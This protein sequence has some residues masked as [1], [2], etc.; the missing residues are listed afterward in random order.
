[1]SLIFKPFQI[2]QLRIK[3]RFIRSATVDN[4]GKDMM[5]SQSQLDLYHELTLGEMG[6]IISSGLFPSLDGWAAPGQLGIH[7]D[8]MIPSLAKLVDIVHRNDGKLAAQIMHA[9]WFGNPELCGY[10]AIGP[11]AMTNPANNLQVR[12]LSSEEVYECVEIFIQAAR[13][14]IEAGFDAVQ[15]HCAHSWLVSAFLSP[16]T[17]LREDE[18]GGSIEKRARFLVNIIQGVRRLA[19]PDFPILIKLGLKDYHPLGKSLNEGINSAQMFINAGVDAIE[20]SEGIE[21]QPF[22][23]I[24]PD[25]VKP[26]YTEECRQARPILDVPV[27][28]VGGMRS[29]SEINQ[30]VDNGIADAVSMCRPF[31]MDQ[32]IVKKFRLKQTKGSECISCNKCIEEMHKQNIH[33]IFNERLIQNPR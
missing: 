29:L 32:H 13:R 6:L 8:N 19:G 23:H 10:Q 11:S 9:G 33:C 25:A 4:L 5:V 28:L 3:N 17:N 26:Y 31:I 16:V 24:R 30:I 20:I 21:Q 18:W 2:N 14:A 7:D 1:M 27:I 12:G 15:I 22:H